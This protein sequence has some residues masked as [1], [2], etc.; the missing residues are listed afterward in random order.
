MFRVGSTPTYGL[1]DKHCVDA[2]ASKPRFRCVG[3]TDGRTDGHMPI[4]ALWGRGGAP[5]RDQILPRP[6]R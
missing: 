6:A 3:L 1:T 2:A 4:S 5:A